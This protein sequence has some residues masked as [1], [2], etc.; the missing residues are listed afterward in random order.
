MKNFKLLLFSISVLLITVSCSEE[1][2]ENKVA[3]VKIS[4]GYINY[5]SAFTS[6]V[7]QRNQEIKFILSKPAVYPY[8][9]GGELPSDIISVSPEVDGTLTLEDQYTV[10]FKPD[11]LLNSA[12]VFN[13]K[14]N[15]KKLVDAKGEFADFPFQFQTLKQNIKLVYHQY[16]PYDDSYEKNYLEAS[17]FS[18]D[19][20]E[21]EKLEKLIF[22]EQGNRKLPLKFIRKSNTEIS[23]VAD[24]VIRRKNKEF[25]F[26]S[27]DGESIGI[28]D[29]DNFKINIPSINSFEV[30]EVRKGYSPKRFIEI[31]F[32]LPVSDNQNIKSFVSVNG[33]RY[34]YTIDKTVLKIFPGS[35]NNDNNV[36]ISEGLASN[37]DKKLTKKHISKITFKQVKPEI[38]IIGKGVIMPDS[39]GLI[40]PFKSIGLKEVKV[41]IVRVFENN[42]GQFF[43]S[44]NF[45]GDNNLKRV[46]RP[47]YNN[48]IPLNSDKAIN[49]NIWNNFNVDISKLI[50]IEPGAIYQVKLSFSKNN[51]VF[52][53][54]DSKDDS[55][56]AS[57]ENDNENWD[58]ASNYNYYDDYY[59]DDY[60]PQNYNWKERNNPCSTSYYTGSKFVS[61][62]LISSNLGLICKQDE[63]GTYQVVVS[64]LR[65][66]LPV[67]EAKVEIFNFQN[68]PLTSGKTNTEGIS[69]LITPKKGYYI[70]VES[71]EQKSYLRIDDGTSLS[72]SKFDIAGKKS[73]KGIKGYIYG[74]RGVWRPGDTLHLTFVLENKSKTL[75]ENYPVTFELYNPMNQLVQREVK[76]SS[77]NG[78]YTFKAQTAGDAATGKWYVKA[79]LADTEFTKTLRIETT[80]PNRLKVELKLNNKVIKAKSNNK[81]TLSSRWLHGANA[82]SL[83]ASVKLNLKPVKTTFKGYSHYIFDD[84]TKSF[85]SEESVVFDGKLNQNGEKTFSYSPKDNDNIPGMLKARFTSFVYEKS[86]DY[87]LNTQDFL[88]SNYNN[89]VG[90]NIK[91]DDKNHNMIYTAKDHIVDIATVNA[92]GNKVNSSVSYKIYKLKWSWWWSSDNDNIA[93]Y[94]ANTDYIV[95]K[96][97]TL[98]TKNGQ[99]S[100]KFKFNNNE[101]G[102]YLILVKD[103]I[104]GHTTGKIVYIDWP[105]WSSRNNPNPEAASMLTFNSDKDKYSV[106]DDVV[107][108]VPTSGEGRALVSIEKGDKILQMFWADTQK[109]LTKI[110]FK[111]SAD[112]SPNVYANITYI[113][114][115]SQTINDLPIRMYGAT[116]VYVEDPNSHINPVISSPKSIEP[117][118]NYKITLS[119][120]NNKAMTYTLA[121]V[122]EGLLDLTNFNT[123]DLWKHFYKKEALRTRTWDMYD[124][125][126]GSFGSKLEQ[127]FAVGGDSELIKKGN[128][129]A[130]RFVP[131][132]KFI[133]PFNLEQ[134]KSKTHKLKMPN[135][136]GSVKVMVVAGNNGA[137]GKADVAIP[138]KK[139]LMVLATLPRV[140]GSNETCDLP[141][142]V[143]AMD[144]KI[145]SAKIT[146][147]VNDKLN[148]EGN[149]TSTLNF[150]NTGEKISYFRLKTSNKIGVAKVVVT[151]ES[152][153]IKAKHEIELDVR[154]PN[155][156]VSISEE[157]MLENKLSINKKPFG[158]ENTNKLSIE[159]SSMPALNLEKRLSY[160]IQY[161]HGCIEQ[162]TSSVFPQLYLSK[163]TN[164]SSGRVSEIEHNIKEAINR[165]YKFQ[166]SD[167]GM[168]YWQGATTANYWGTNYAGHFMLEAEK[169][170]YALPSGFKTKWVKYQSK[171]ANS[172][173]ATDQY[174]SSSV[175]AYR[176]YT[177]ALANKAAVGA[178]NR[179]KEQNIDTEARALLA[180]AYA[181]IG[182]KDIAKEL[183][184]KNTQQTQVSKKHYYYSYGSKDR[185]TAVFLY[186]YAGIKEKELSFNTLKRVAE[187]LSGEKY[188]S[189]QTAAFS[190]L[191][192][193]KYISR[194]NP[195][196]NI[197]IEYSIDGKSKSVESALP[198]YTINFDNYE[199][200]KNVKLENNGDGSLFVRVINSGIPL[201]HEEKE[202][203]R[204][205]TLKVRYTD[206]NGDNIDVGNL[207]QGKEFKAVVTITNNNSIDNIKDIALNQIFP[208]GWEIVN[209]RLLGTVDKTSDQ[210]D[211]IDIR[212]DRVYQYFDLRQSETKTFTVSLIAAYSGEYYLSGVLA[213]AMYNDSFKAMIKGK[214][215]IVTK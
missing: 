125:V 146:V 37:N 196:D 160:L 90:M 16:K 139:P 32:S 20:I 1:I 11:E 96:E 183:L 176:L 172:W 40:F 6:G 59:Y 119:E 51:I 190:L 136:V 97:G 88:Y 26:L 99:G 14:L 110:K 92:E 82:G 201:K 45:S 163:L 124:F 131:V 209:S 134:G 102:R 87:S 85:S 186:A 153:G 5:I 68:Q 12:T 140:L 4:Q 202:F 79:K 58:A 19:F 103:K 127:M 165:L 84:P 41:R 10:V 168:S 182:Q 57:I 158:V 105:N 212:D 101:W 123:P 130:N 154:N 122:D 198:V 155:P 214:K 15:L 148:I 141:I 115:H 171:K 73:K 91:L 195:D 178:M 161:P 181:Q 150:K 149:S 48:T 17:V 204:N 199:K 111:A 98:S 77:V 56:L 193:Q 106:G 167:G 74:E 152:N 71:E 113:Q 137:Y 25:V 3:P 129:K 13:G 174:T 133:G 107:L 53:C 80:K 2:T 213:E 132:V 100:F 117:E 39:D 34:D 63:S 89:Y 118:S 9:A 35:D 8:E 64:D 184:F 151:V 169:L 210:P 81:L 197:D 108:N 66:T 203:S 95:K 50:D 7:I 166:L 173:S 54:G 27:Y 49:Y 78:F 24:S 67:A 29:S 156:P 194:F 159:V 47:I 192:V 142:T 31:V 215:V 43:Q 44:N 60:Y 135:Y 70:K 164:L 72:Y 175:Q 120:K 28:D 83:K 112:M 144:K 157:Y 191:A 93:H 21:D 180:S 36:I 116:P 187:N 46:G 189:T 208:S 138:V 38:E 200:S 143:F 30:L 205:L 76:N 128:K 207:K 179:L 114:K 61:K 104:S 55:S 65:T 185:E 126:M 18:S 69:T 145:K 206:T 52:N 170:G 147:K 75:P 86:G 33:D 94:I 62:N 23:V 162:T 177:L 188:M 22:A 121:V 211:Y 42:M 109:G